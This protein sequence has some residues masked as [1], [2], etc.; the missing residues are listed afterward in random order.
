[1]SEHTASE[2]PREAARSYDDPHGAARSS[3]E[4]TAGP[5]DRDPVDSMQTETR[6]EDERDSSEGDPA[7]EDRRGGPARR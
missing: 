2:H 6:G 4:G 7:E 1:M 5:E 3:L